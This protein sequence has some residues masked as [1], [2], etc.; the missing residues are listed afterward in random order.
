MLAMD[1]HQAWESESLSKI[2]LAIWSLLESARDDARC[3]CHT[4]VV[5]TTA[6]SSWSPLPRVRTVVLR[7]VDRLGRSLVFHTDAR[8][9]KVHELTAS[10][11][12]EWLFYDRSEKVQIRALATATVHLVARDDEYA[13]QRWAASKLSSRRCYTV[14]LS[15]GSKVDK[16]T[17][18]LPDAL[19]SRAP[20]TA[21]SEAGRENFAVVSTEVSAMD[22]LYLCADGNR[23]ASFS[24]DGEQWHGSWLVP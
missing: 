8:S 22:W 15:P 23:R 6:R 24:W 13:I 12:L 11:K 3:E 10:P 4:P 7:D 20:T 21:E 18:W 9:H 16:P 1:L 5:A 17:G 19:V 2:E 14:K